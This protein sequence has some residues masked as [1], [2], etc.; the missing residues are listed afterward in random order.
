MIIN[1]NDLQ[2]LFHR[3]ALGAIL[4]NPED[5][6]YMKFLESCWVQDTDLFTQTPTSDTT[7][8]AMVLP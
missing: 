1:F 4:I 8:R 5:V 2:I 6:R 7:M 3:L